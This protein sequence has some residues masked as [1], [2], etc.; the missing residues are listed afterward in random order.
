MKLRRIWH[1]GVSGGGGG[2][3]VSDG[4]GKWK[5]RL[6]VWDYR[7]GEWVTWQWWWC[8]RGNS[9]VVLKWWWG[10]RKIVRLVI[11]SFWEEIKCERGLEFGSWE[12][13]QGGHIHPSQCNCKWRTF[14]FSPML[15]ELEGMGII[16]VSSFGP[17]F[18]ILFIHFNKVN[19]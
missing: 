9:G 6:R 16:F 3:V 15:L 2:C 19:F 11:A 18:F 1:W 13:G 4:W 7:N 5:R 14:Y 10:R 17:W 12:L 8:W